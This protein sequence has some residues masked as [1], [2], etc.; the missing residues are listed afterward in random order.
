MGNVRQLT[1]KTNVIHCPAAPL[2]MVVIAIKEVILQSKGGRA[3]Q[4]S[5]A[6]FLR[7]FDCYNKAASAIC[8]YHKGNRQSILALDQPWFL[9]ASV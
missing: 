7:D 4:D 3:Y 8:Y 2:L 5:M 1:E 6:G 9:T